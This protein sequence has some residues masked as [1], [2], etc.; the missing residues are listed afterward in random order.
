M[1]GLKTLYARFSDLQMGKTLDDGVSLGDVTTKLNSIG[2]QVL[3]GNGNMRGVGDIMEDLMGVWSSIDQTQKAAVAQTLAGKYQ[4]SRFEALMNRSDLYNQYKDAS[5]N[6]DG[7]LDVMNEKY[8]DS[9]QGRLNKLQAS[10]E[11]LFNN[12]FDTDDFYAPIDALTQLVDLTNEF[13]QSIGGVKGALTALAPIMTQVFSKNIAQSAMSIIQN[14]QMDKINKNNRNT[15]YQRLSQMGLQDVKNPS[16]EHIV[17]FMEST[18]PNAKYMSAGQQQEY[19]SM[20]SETVELS[21]KINSTQDDIVKKVESTA[22]AYKLVGQD[23]SDLN[24]KLDEEGRLVEVNTKGLKDRKESGKR[25]VT[26][27]DLHESNIAQYK[28]AMSK[29]KDIVDGMDFTKDFSKE[30]REA[31]ANAA[32]GIDEYMKSLNLTTKQTEDVSSASEKLFDTLLDDSKGANDCKVQFEALKQALAEAAETGEKIDLS[33]IVKDPQQIEQLKAELD[34]LGITMDTV[35]EKENAFASGLNLQGMLTNIA[36]VAGAIG[37]LAFAY[38]QIQS[39]GDIW[40]DDDLTSSEKIVQTITSLGMAIPMVVQAL[41]SLKGAFT[42][43]TNGGIANG[44][45]AIATQIATF[46]GAEVAATG[47]TVTLSTAL[48]AL[49]AALFSISP[50]TAAIGIGLTALGVIGVSVFNTLTKDAQEVANAQ[51]EADGL[52]KTA[53][54][55][56]TEYQEI[57]NSYQNLQDTISN[58]KESQDAVEK[59]QKGTDEWKQ[60]LQEANSQVLDLLNSY[61]QLSKYVQKDSNGKMS[62]AQEGLD[63]LQQEQEQRNAYGQMAVA[64][65]QKQASDAQ[66]YANNKELAAKIKYN[67]TE[68]RTLNASNDAVPNRPGTQTGINTVYQ[69]AVSKSISQDALNAIYNML[70]NKGDDSIRSKEDIKEALKSNGLDADNNLIKAIV[71]NGDKIVDQLKVNDQTN[72][73]TKEQM[74]NAAQ[75]ALD[76]TDGYDSNSKYNDAIVAETARRADRLTDKYQKKYE[77]YDA[78]T[79]GQMYANQQG[80]TFDKEKDGK[81]TFTDA[82][83]QE[84]SVSKDVLTNYLVAASAMDEAAKNWQDSAKAV[85]DVA[86]SAFGKRY[87]D[88]LVDTVSEGSKKDGFDFSKW[89]DSSLESI[90]SNSKIK[91]SDLGI[92]NEEAKDAGFKSGKEYAKAF[93]NAAKDEM[94]SRKDGG[95]FG[96]DN[97]MSTDQIN[98]KLSALGEDAKNLDSYKENLKSTNKEFAKFSDSI[99]KQVATLNKQNSELEESNKNLDANSSKWKNN[100][101]KMD[102]NKKT[103]SKLNNS[104][105]DLTVKLVESQQGAEE[106]QKVFAKTKNPFDGVE[107]KSAEYDKTLDSMASSAGKLLNIDISGWSNKAKQSFL[108][109]A[110]NLKDMEAAANGDAEAL[111]RLRTAA[112]EQILVNMGLDPNADANVIGAA[113]DLI[114]WA[115]QN[116]PNIEAGADINSTQYYATLNKMVQD[117]I[118]AGM[119]MSQVLDLLSAEGIE[120]QVTYTQQMVK[121]PKAVQYNPGHDVGSGEAGVGYMQHSDASGTTWTYAYE[122][123]SVPNFTFKKVNS[124]KPGTSYKGSGGSGGGGHKTGSG[125]GSGGKG[126]SGGG[127]GSGSGSGSTYT[128][129]DNKSIENEID[130]YEKVNTQLDKISAQYDK[131][132]KERD[133]LS[134]KALAKSITKEN[135][136]LN[137]QIELQNEKLKIQQKEAADVKAQLSSKYGVTF[138]AEGFISNYASVYNG[139][140]NKVNSIGSKYSSLTSESAEKALDKEYDAAEKALDDFNKKY[141]R[142]D[143]LWG[144]D[145]EDTTSKIEDL[146]DS[147]EDLNI[148]I[149]KKQVDAIDSIKD[150]DNA[151]IEFERNLKSGRVD[152]PFESIDDE[153]EKM[154]NY[155]GIA[156]DDVNEYYDN[157]IA[158][159]KE[160]IHSNQSSAAAKKWAQSQIEAL[161]EARK[162]E[163]DGDKTLNSN[164]TGYFDMTL[165]NLQ[166]MNEQIKQYKETGK[167]DIFGEDSADLYDVAQDI[168]DQ[169]TQQLS[170][171]RDLWDNTHDKIISMIDEIGDALDRRKDQYDAI[172]DE[173]EH[174]LN[175]IEMIHGDEAYAKSNQILDAQT[176]AYKS[177]LIELQKQRDIWQNMLN[178]L[179]E[180]TRDNADEWD[181]IHDKIKGATSDINDLIE[182]SLEA[183]QKKYSNAVANITKTWS[184]SAMGNDLDWMNTEWELINRNADYYLD[185]TNKAYNV[186][187][188]QSKY[189]DLL[190]G[191]NDLAIQKKVTDQMNQQL[192]Y[193]R[194]KTK[195]SEYDVNYA[196]AQLEI[197][198]KQ[199]ALE[200]AQ[201]NKSQM[202]LRRDSQGNYSYVYAANE[203]NVRSAQSDLLDAQNS[204]YNLSK[205]QMKQTQDDSLSALQDAKS[206]IDDI[207][208]DANTTLE[209]KKKR[210]QTIIDSLNEYLSSTSEQLSTSEKNIINDFLGMCN[211]LTDE[212]MK[213][214]QD[215]YQQIVD[216][217]KDA[218]DQID[219]RWSTSISTWLGNVDQIKEN[220]QNLIDDLVQAGEDFQKSTDDIASTVK[221]NFD[222]ITNAVNKTNDAVK[223]LNESQ[224]QFYSD[225]DSMSGRVLQAEKGLTEY[226]K[227]INDLNN[228][229]AAYRKQVEEL[230]KSLKQEQQENAN[231]RSTI[232]ANQAANGQ[233]NGGAGSGNGGSGGT[234]AANARVG[235]R[236]GFRGQYYYD[237][238]GKRPAGHLYAGQ[239]GAVIIDS[240]S[241]TSYGGSSRV[242]GG[243][244]VHIKSADG[245]YGNLGWISPSQMFDT[246]GYTGSW[247][248]DG[249]ALAN[250]GKLAWLHE[251]ELVLNASDTEN[252][253]K[254]V[255]MIRSYAE[256]FKNSTAN[257][258]DAY[259]NHFK[260]LQAGFNLNSGQDVNQNVH[261]TAEFPAANS[262]AEIE[263]AL[264][265]LNE[266]AIQH[267]YKTK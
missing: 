202:K 60:S 196:Q 113:Q 225:L 31:F 85:S 232:N 29:S 248:G 126:G 9:L 180:R 241:S 163:L 186:Q 159:H 64:R 169:A 209:E 4:L 77:G 195:L 262:A 265:S 99:E 164:G 5:E 8:V 112:A 76:N 67:T 227:K 73:Q 69:A 61:P 167:S 109:N 201:R 98:S 194:D 143:E 2:V 51:K 267:V 188:L 21:N 15:A 78:N 162:S 119:T 192:A 174:Q 184:S 25:M 228:D 48:K 52:A 242:T 263:S 210:T 129:K 221:T 104:Y 105:D 244:K 190:D 260:N 43:L 94:Q 230:Q 154:H 137:R 233:S 136:L 71:A 176:N 236:V 217:N 139:L 216:G 11:G 135:Q 245:K 257:T 168:F 17:D 118:A 151:L 59:L 106:L 41:V 178:G 57:Q 140:V 16:N 149:F 193:L 177:Q 158:K 211:S 28:K 171:Y 251:K 53:S 207:W 102:E 26:A 142:Y 3:D 156:T 189:L 45:M 14:A 120:A 111:Q 121:T 249:V 87:G 200:E 256:F 235:S 255:E 92:S 150:L 224:S 264:L 141:Q 215:V 90:A 23:V 101:A 199:I 145:I 222:D 252:I 133:R 191:S 261:I 152:N 22:A 246:G 63:E 110:Q 212:N 147:I 148:E 19:N 79:L 206:M 238:W 240:Y 157:L 160:V 175:I 44:I 115:N 205:D 254:A 220:N 185:S 250:D 12:L 83:G 66:I 95:S 259:A 183:L 165:K 198:Q 24:V 266:L 10:A 258:A 125:S 38:Q 132:N 75:T 35:R 97:I 253:L 153:F 37:N 93:L 47:A 127:K 58:Y 100:K 237:S 155:F 213:D 172:N 219:D 62:I 54:E 128:P 124:F 204:A 36:N 6:A 123:V 46:T 68:T 138:D 82:S 103:I 144:Q 161:D 229:M 239:Q 34:G 197:L 96:T 214:M 1:N 187:K 80:W 70:R 18:L 181:T 40:S 88:N 114:N 131:V 179:G 55:V 226:Q 7:T 116:L 166:D 130:L 91:A 108:D 13:M 65:A 42:F 182:T 117:C 122:P 84:Q 247:S 170:D 203:D 86:N 134:G 30:S 49:K 56:A 146:K 173:L 33:K 39:I 234:N 208:N 89:G 32:V 74:Q 81:Y 27:D 218:F 243:Y 50:V 107:K 223:D 20:L 72:A 231:L